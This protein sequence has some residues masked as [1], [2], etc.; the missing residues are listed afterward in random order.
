MDEYEA[1]AFLTDVSYE[2]RLESIKTLHNI[3]K[4]NK[5]KSKFS[6]LY[7]IARGLAVVLFDKEID[8]RTH[9]LN[10]VVDFINGLEENVCN[11]IHAIV[12]ALLTCLED[13]RS[14]VQLNA[15]KC[16]KT[17]LKKTE[18]F[19]ATI[20][21][22]ISEGLN[23]RS[24]KISKSVISKLHLIVVD[25]KANRHIAKLIHALYNKLSNKFMQTH[26]FESL[27][28]LKNVLGDKL[29][30]SY[31]KDA[32]EN[33]RKIYNYLSG[34]VRELSFIDSLMKSEELFSSKDIPNYDVDEEDDDKN[35]KQ[36]NLHSQ[37]VFGFLSI[38]IYDR[39]LKK[40]ST[41]EK[42]ESLEDLKF[43][44]KNPQNNDALEKNFP[45]F[46]EFLLKLFDVSNMQ[47]NLICLDIIKV[48]LEQYGLKLKPY[49]NSFIS[50]IFPFICTDVICLKESVFKLVKIIFETLGIVSSAPPLCSFLKHSRSKLRQETL[51]F[52]M[53]LLLTMNMKVGEIEMFVGPVM[54]AL[55][56]SKKLIRQAAMECS[57]L[58]GHFL[59]A[60]KNMKIVSCLHNLEQM[61]RGSGVT[62]A[63]NERF[64]LNKLPKCNKDGTIKYTAINN[65]IAPLV[66]EWVLL[67]GNCMTRD[68]QGRSVST[69]EFNAAKDHKTP[70]FEDN[71][72]SKSPSPWHGHNKFSKQDVGKSLSRAFVDVATPQAF[73]LVTHMPFPTIPTFTRFNNFL[74]GVRAL[75]SLMQMFV[76]KRSKEFAA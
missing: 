17:C 42:V 35:A 3:L 68:T 16:L 63:V 24:K 49:T 48:L 12:P 52:V 28:K 37:L 51:N 60:N 53:Y 54:E 18:N 15:V 7:E 22:I 43:I 44:C 8:V 57:A 6:D 76:S 70:F 59:N 1:I 62:K 55:L 2:S 50:N 40:D 61:P 21:L 74:N 26:G 46:L 10:F 9:G 4:I 75:A 71:N 30:Q 25:F 47:T 19:Q 32:D 67:A 13:N 23:S 38:N 11:C 41:H 33:C 14:G 58:L 66:L 56:D 39:L 31:S 29:F 34:D 5:G 65:N 69:D 45:Q 36:M 72:E 64:N 73:L 20:D 27:K